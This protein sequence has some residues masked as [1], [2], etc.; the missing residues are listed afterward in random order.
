M[1]LT[2]LDTIQSTIGDVAQIQHSAT[3]HEQIIYTNFAFMVGVHARSYGT[4]FSTFC[5]SQQIDEA[6][7]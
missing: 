3:D 7:Q 5:T 2:L 1:G 6:H 4:I